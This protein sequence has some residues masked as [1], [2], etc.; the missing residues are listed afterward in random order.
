MKQLIFIECIVMPF[1][2]LGQN[3]ENQDSI[4]ER[5]REDSIF[6]K[7]YQERIERIT[8]KEICNVPFGCSY[9]KAETILENKYGS[10]KFSDRTQIVYY[11]KTY[12][13]ITFYKICFLFQ[14]DGVKSY[15]N[16]CIFVLESKTILEARDNQEKLRS[17]LSYKY[18]MSEGKDKNNEIYY[19]GGLPPKNCKDGLLM[20]GFMIDIIKNN[21]SGYI[22]RLYYGRYN[23]INEEF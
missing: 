4:R 12:A 16:G 10:S 8:V 3:I 14:S 6:W 9:E 17:K 13:G 21:S 18:K 1:I 22:T 15:M 23:Y 11:D 20:P 2:V 19:F 5:E 7:E